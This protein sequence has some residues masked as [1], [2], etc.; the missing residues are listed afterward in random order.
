MFWAF[1][2]K[3]RCISLPLL[4][5]QL[6]KKGIK[7]QINQK[8]ENVSVATVAWCRDKF[9]ATMLPGFKLTHCDLQYTYFNI[10]FQFYWQ[11]QNFI[12]S[13]Y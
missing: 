7:I 9:E 6:K 11:Y 2:T 5:W 10:I 13:F 12:V 8:I 1:V 4:N 3:F